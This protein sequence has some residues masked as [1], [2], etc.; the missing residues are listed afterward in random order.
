MAGVGLIVFNPCFPREWD[1]FAIV[2]GI[3]LIA[4]V[5]IIGSALAFMRLCGLI[6]KVMAWWTT[7][8]K[9]SFR[10]TDALLDEAIRLEQHG[11]WDKA[12]KLCERV[13]R[14]SVS[15]NATHATNCIVRLHD[16]RNRRQ[17]LF[18][19]GRHRRDRK[20]PRF[21]DSSARRSGL[22]AHCNDCAD[23]RTHRN[24]HNSLEDSQIGEGPDRSSVLPCLE[25]VPRACR[26]PNDHHPDRGAHLRGIDSLCGRPRR[27]HSVETRLPTPNPASRGFDLNPDNLPAGLEA[28]HQEVL[29]IQAAIKA[30]QDNL[31]A[32]CARLTPLAATAQDTAP[33]KTHDNGRR[34]V[35]QALRHEQHGDWDEAIALYEQAAKKWPEQA[36]FP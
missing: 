12:I 28:E 11:E 29:D 3:L 36:T 13:A 15:E 9:R 35:R 2:T 4:I 1:D 21:W 10:S 30:C 24:C 23:P 8:L 26:R 14:K 6:I 31:T 16:H 5:L 18:H 33:A 22:S 27:T 25:D 7:C 19:M 34:L 32:L 20:L 17:S